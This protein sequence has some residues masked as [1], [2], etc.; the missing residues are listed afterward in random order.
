MRIGKLSHFDS[1]WRSAASIEKKSA[2]GWSNSPAAHI[3]NWKKNYN[4]HHRKSHQIGYNTRGKIL[5]QSNKISQP[6]LK[7]FYKSN[8]ILWSEIRQKWRWKFSLRCAKSSQDHKTWAEKG[9]E[10]RSAN[11]SLVI[12][13]RRTEIYWNIFETEIQTQHD[14]LLCEEERK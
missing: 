12:V 6:G 1:D 2:P 7:S 4:I 8:N 13:R 5:Y 14:V 11:L 3:S 9:V 10:E